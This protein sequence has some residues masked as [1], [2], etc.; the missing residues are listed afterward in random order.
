MSTS[1][2]SG[3]PFTFSLV[4][5]NHDPDNW[6]EMV[7]FLRQ[8][9]ADGLKIKGQVLGRPVRFILGH[10]LT[11]HPFYS[12]E[13]YRSL[14]HLPFEE[15]IERLHVNPQS[16][17]ALSPNCRIPIRSMRSAAQS[18]SSRPCSS[19]KTTHRTTSSH[20]R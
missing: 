6:R 12:T 9:N 5:T 17:P 15:R 14:A 7:A 10:E 4:Q 13:T 16:G 3:R 19:Y 11:L 20:R 18:A 8:A 2:R 1:P